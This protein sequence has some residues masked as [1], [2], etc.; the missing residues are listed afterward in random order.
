VEPQDKNQEDINIS[1]YK[2]VSQYYSIGDSINKFIIVYILFKLSFL[3]GKTLILVKDVD[4]IYKMKIFL[5]R[6]GIKSF[7][8]YNPEDPKNLKYYVLTIFN[9]GMIKTIIS[10]H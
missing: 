3:S 2:M 4:S 8:I 10:T 7:S 6:I 1:Q 9:T 5:E